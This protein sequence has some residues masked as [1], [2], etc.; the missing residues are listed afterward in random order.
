MAST[1]RRIAT[2]C[3]QR[4]TVSSKPR[5]LAT[6]VSASVVASPL[7]A[8]R[9]RFERRRPACVSVRGGLFPR[10][11]ALGG[12]LLQ[13]QHL[14]HQA[15]LD[16]L[17]V[18]STGRSPRTARSTCEM[19]VC[20]VDISAPMVG[21][22]LAQRL[23]HRHRVLHAL[24]PL[25]RRGASSSRPS[26]RQAALNSSRSPGGTPPAS[27]VRHVSNRSPSCARAASS[28][29]TRKIAQQATSCRRAGRRSPPGRPRGPDAGY[30]G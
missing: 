12:D 29:A 1:K 22:H 5:R 23:D 27:A 8:D 24:G 14:G 11:P 16:L 3:T 19:L 7:T 30:P 9:S 17:R 4:S 13:R 28:S 21:H 20:M 15:R 26:A 2:C 10:A 25:L 6:P 18:R